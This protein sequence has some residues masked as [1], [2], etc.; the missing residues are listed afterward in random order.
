MAVE[1][2][3]STYRDVLQALQSAKTVKIVVDLHQCHLPG[4]TEAGPAV[5]GG[6]VISAFNVVP[7]KGILF[8]DIHS[9]LNPAGKPIADYIRYAL[10]ENNEL[11]LTVT[12]ISEEGARREESFRCPVPNAA[13]FIW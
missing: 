5:V 9:T 4:G 11:T 6:L 1:Y 7:G 12:H 13:K 2:D 3:N 8:S 10:A